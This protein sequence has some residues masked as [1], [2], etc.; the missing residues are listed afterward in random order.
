MRKK[1]LFALLLVFVVC[2]SLT[3][4]SA[5]DNDNKINSSGAGGSISDASGNSGSVTVCSINFIADGAVYAKIYRNECDYRT[6]FKTNARI[7]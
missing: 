4:F 1:I 7:Q 2:L 5:C 3:L 6:C